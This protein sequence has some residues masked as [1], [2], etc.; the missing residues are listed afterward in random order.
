MEATTTVDGAARPQTEQLADLPLPVL[1]RRLSDQTTLLM[2]EEVAL[3]KAELAEK[4]RRAGKG[5]GMLGGAALFGLFAFGALTTAAILALDL[6]LAGWLAAL[7]VG[8]VYAAIAA[9]AALAG[10]GQVQRATPPMPEQTVETLK[11]DVRWTKAR[12]QAAR[13]R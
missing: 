8:V 3:A 4:G 9:G 1:L 7:V 12:A 6:V 10:K 13:S 2:R 5:A 11:E